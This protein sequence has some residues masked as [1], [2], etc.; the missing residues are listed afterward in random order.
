MGKMS[1]PPHLFSPCLHPFPP[2]FIY[3]SK[4]GIGQN[5]KSVSFYI[6]LHILHFIIRDLPF[7]LLSL[8][9]FSQVDQPSRRNHLLLFLS[10][11]PNGLQNSTFLFSSPNLK[12]DNCKWDATSGRLRKLATNKK[13]SHYFL[14][15]FLGPWSQPPY[16][17]KNL[18]S[19]ILEFICHSIK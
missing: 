16:L 19:W 14:S 6:L 7:I 13:Y 3:A 15:N 18:S 8:F 2:L 17:F 5:M 11:N 10:S 9:I 4:L 1:L 12:W